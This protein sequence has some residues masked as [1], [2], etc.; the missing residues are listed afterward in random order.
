MQLAE[1]LSRSLPGMPMSAFVLA[2][3][4]LAW[5]VPN[6]Y[7]PWLSAWHEGF[8]LW[9]LALAALLQSRPVRLPT[10][11]GAAIAVALASVGIQW[12]SG[13]ILFGGDA[14]MAALYLVAFA[15]AIGLGSTL[16]AAAAPGRSSALDVVAIGVVVAA[17]ASVA[18]AL[19]QWTGVVS[20]G[21]YA[22]DL[23]RGARPFA[24]VAQPNHLCTL[25]FFGLCSLAV[26]RASGRVGALG[27]WLGGAFLLFGM[28]MSASRTGWVQIVVL[29]LLMAMLQRRSTTAPGWKAALMLALLF[30]AGTLAWPLL[31]DALL[32][33]G[34]RGVTVQ[35]D[36]GVR[37]PLWWSLLDAIVQRPW[38]GYG[39]QQAVLAQQAAA[40][41][42]P[43]TLRQFE[44]SHNVVLD[45]LLWAGIPAGGLIIGLIAMALL[46]QFRAAR[47]PRVTWLF[48][49]VAGALAH[50]MLEFPHE[51]AYFLLPVGLALGAMHAIA[52]VGG[53][54]RVKVATVR[55][56]GASA[57]LL[58]G[59]ISVDYLK[60]EQA[61][62]V[63]RLESARIGVSGI[64]T[65]AP[66]LRLLTQLGSFLRFAQTEAGEGM[67][68]DEVDWMRKVAQRFAFPPAMFRYALAAGLNGQ[69]ARASLTLNRLCRIHP[70][71]RCEEARE[72]WQAAQAKFPGLMGIELP[73]MP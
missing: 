30:V 7:F 14:L 32:L 71:P 52:P 73:P 57:A 35:M 23:P 26:V 50:A 16:P 44:H 11:W 72:G 34:G 20:L 1:R 42:H 68:V 10:L 60:A 3:L 40:L 41:D 59:A 4:P 27:F 61:Y 39:W 38:T 64:T 49:A 18:V 56:L 21:I 58:L 53:E 54:W 8:A 13:V 25:A 28:V 37:G 15:L 46:R 47:D 6:H 24:N 22:A 19:V 65:P 70:R 66:E 33:A 48:V 29:V 12:L 55:V 36:G 62:R 43:A 45:V 69:A 31:N 67:T 17:C 5:L 63:L 9:L 51:Y 2:A